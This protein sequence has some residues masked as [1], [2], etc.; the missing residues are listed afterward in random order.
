MTFIGIFYHVLDLL[1]RNGHKTNSDV[2]S[3]NKNEIGMRLHNVPNSTT[4]SNDVNLSNLNEF[5]HLNDVCCSD[6]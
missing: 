5:T 4:V 2:S 6:V 1:N 3:S